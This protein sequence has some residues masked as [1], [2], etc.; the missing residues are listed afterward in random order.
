MIAWLRVRLAALR[1]RAAEIREALEDIW[2]ELLA[3]RHAR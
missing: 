2:A 1:C 3:E